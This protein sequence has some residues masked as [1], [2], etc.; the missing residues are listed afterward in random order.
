MKR[1]LLAEA[2]G[3]MMLVIIG[4]GAIVMNDKTSGS[5]T[6]IGICASFGIIVGVLIYTLSHISSCH[7]NP[8]VSIAL[9]L[10][11]RFEGKKV[12]PYISAQ[13]VGAIVGSIIIKILFP[14]SEDLGATIPKVS[15]QSAF[16]IELII[17]A[18]LF[19][20]VLFIT[21]YTHKTSAISLT[22]G[23]VVFILAMIAGPY[24][25]A[26]MNP[27]RSIGPAIVSGNFTSLWLYLIAPTLGMMIPGLVIAKTGCNPHSFHSSK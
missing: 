2:F 9:W 3:T 5:I 22:I 10:E 17:S 8:S 1:Q 25:G 14:S 16:T 20:S 26:S 21:Y 23:I 27:A 19:S 12:L 13:I 6:H 15:I 24:T 4:T 11:K 7:I 18:V